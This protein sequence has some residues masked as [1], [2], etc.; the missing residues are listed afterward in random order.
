[1]PSLTINPARIVQARHRRG[2]SQPDVAFRLRERGHKTDT[3]TIS[4]W[5]TGK[6][7]PHGNIIPDLAAVLGVTIDKLYERSESGDDEEDEAALRRLAR[8]ALD[9][10]QDDLALELI[11]RAVRRAEARA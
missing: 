2:F 7:T 9:R 3:A 6:N 10:G 5:E 11:E 1:V 4:R 8:T